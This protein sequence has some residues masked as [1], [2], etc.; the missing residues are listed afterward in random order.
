MTVNE[1]GTT[2]VWLFFDALKNSSNFT[3]WGENELGF[4]KT[5][6]DAVVSRSR[7][8]P[9]IVNEKELSTERKAS[10]VSIQDDR[11]QIRSKSRT[12]SP[13]RHLISNCK[14]P[15]SVSRLDS[16]PI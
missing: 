9:L 12:F 16:L 8:Q 5:I 11:S 1:G 15:N 13:K 7:R 6:C 4:A 2:Q 10:R 14:R 3:E